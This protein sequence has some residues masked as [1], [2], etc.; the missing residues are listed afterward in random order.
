MGYNIKIS[1]IIPAYNV[2][3]YLDTCLESLLN[4]SLQ[5]F[6]IIVIDDGSTDKTP[7]ILQKYAQKDSRIKVITQVNQKQGAA[8]NRGLE[9]AQGE[10]ITFIDADD[11]V[12]NNYFEAMYCT[13]KKYDADIAISNSIR[14]KGKKQRYHFHFKEEKVYEGKQ[15]IF[16]IVNMHWE[17]HSKIYRAEIAKKIRFAE[18]VFFEDDGYSIRFLNVST[19]LVTVPNTAYHYI[20]NPTSTIKGKTTLPKIIDRIEASFDAVKYLK[21]NNVNTSDK[22]IIKRGNFIYSTKF[23]IDKE[24]HYLFGVKFLIIKKDFDNNKNFIIYNTS[25]FGDV[26]LC[27]SLCQNIKLAFPESKIIFVVNKPFYEVAKFQKDVDEVLIYDKKGEHKGLLGFI[28]FVKNFPYKNCF[29]SFITYKNV[30][31]YFISKLVKSKYIISG[32]TKEG[33]ISV[34]ERHNSLLKEITHKHIKKFPIKFIAPELE[35]SELK[36]LFFAEKKYVAICPISKKASKDISKDFVKD[37]MNLLNNFDYVPVLTGVGDKAKD[38]S[39]FLLDEGINFIDLVDKTT[40]SELASCLKLCKTLIS[41]DT[42]TMHLGYALE[43]PTVAIFYEDKNEIWMPN[44]ELYK[45][46]VVKNP[47]NVKVIYETMQE[48]L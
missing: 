41:V 38:Y 15:N 22:L 42:G 9:V 39:K 31:N 14:E 30:R 13:S 3:N 34:Q 36:N 2:E 46:V 28:K 20:S 17:P 12:D 7:L 29:C 8:R 11:W 33:N 10:Y 43:L 1:A 25:Y 23:Y 19:K 37:L 16:D 26:L 44:S 21:E 4:Q 47:E 24:V 5:E 35:N 32:K 18:Q 45:T 27:N 48:L 6:E 40:I